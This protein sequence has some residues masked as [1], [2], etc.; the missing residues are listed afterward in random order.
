MQHAAIF[1]NFTPQTSIADGVSVYDFV[2]VATDVRFKKGWAKYAPRVGSEVTPSLPQMNEHYFDW[3]LTLEAVE[4]A[5]DSF[6]MIEL[7]AGWGTWVVTA[8]LA[9]RQRKA[10]KDIE[11]LA[12]E[13]DL[14]HYEWM[15][16][17]FRANGLDL[18]AH[19]LIHGAVSAEPGKIRFPVI[20][21][22]AEDY[23]A[24]TSAVYGGRP[25][26]EVDAYT[27]EE[28]IGRM[29]G[30][31]DFLHVDIQG[32]EYDT[33]PAAMDL[34]KKN[35]KSIMVGTHQSLEQHNK[36]AKLFRDNGWEPRMEYDRGALCDTEYG[37][38][39]FGD[40][41]IAYRNPDL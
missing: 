2:G 17:H 30:P 23:G 4:K 7:G 14:A 11:L 32:A 39:Q 41:L 9:C 31:V 22:P 20:E 27:I 1:E 26:V 38:V 12:I 35:V 24:S 40:G 18:S 36:L 6:R 10:I 25:Y 37:E 21:N 8:A 19:H 5:T 29:K 3:V 33:I 16:R 15:N 13:A 28:L 34:L